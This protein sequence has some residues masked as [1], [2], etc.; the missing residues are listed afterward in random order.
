M[1]PRIY[2]GKITPVDISN[3]LNVEF[4][5]E[6]L[7]T[8]SVG[9]ENRMIIQISTREARSSGGRT[10]ITVIAE[11]IEDG[12]SIQVG[13]HS[14]LGIAASLGQSAIWTWLNPWNLV[15]RLDDIAQDIELFQLDED[16]WQIIEKLARTA[17]ASTQISERLRRNVCLYCSTANTLGEGRC[18]ACGAPLGNVQP[19]TCMNCGFIIKS[20]DKNCPNCG[21]SVTINSTYS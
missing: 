7:Q 3:A 20:T 11:K 9:N 18:I 16:V 17:G 19:Q 8:R 4:N 12:V 15:N 10:A 21:K 6:N 5:R 1:E 2:H 13:E 14:L